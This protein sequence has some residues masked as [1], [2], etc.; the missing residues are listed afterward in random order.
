MIKRDSSFHVLYISDVAKT[1]AFYKGI[2]AVI[3]KVETDK[4][5]VKLGDFDLHFILD[6]TEPW[7]NYSYIAQNNNRGSGIIFYVE[8]ENL[9]DEYERIEKSG[10]RIKST[11]TENWWGANEF[12]FEDPDG[13]KIVFW[14]MKEEIE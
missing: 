2:G 12:L 5:V 3:V 1:E 11:I 10:G 9:S 4:C 7:E 14:E 13:Y 8:A 6:V